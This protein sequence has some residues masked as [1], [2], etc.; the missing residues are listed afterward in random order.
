MCLTLI[1]CAPVILKDPMSGK[2]I[3][4]YLDLDKES[5]LC[6]RYIGATAFHNNYSRYE[7]GARLNNRIYDAVRDAIINSG[8][9]A[10]EIKIPKGVDKDRLTKTDFVGGTTISNYGISFIMNISARHNLDAVFWEYELDHA[11]CEVEISNQ[12]ANDRKNTV[13]V[14]SR[15][16]PVL[17]DGTTG[18]KLGTIRAAFGEESNVQP[19][20]V[21][22]EAVSNKE[23][24]IYIEAAYKYVYTK[25]VK[26]LSGKNSNTSR[27]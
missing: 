21:G 9:S 27:K 24:A 1:S 12:Y 3:G 20:P 16:S 6:Y 22:R 10:Y 19:I 26:L 23:I 11:L 17:F 14:Y 8:N 5:E 13:H 4:I 2:R 18:E 25:L 15:Y 7:L